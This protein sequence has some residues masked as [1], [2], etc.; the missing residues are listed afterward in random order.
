MDATNLISM[1]ARTANVYKSCKTD[2]Q[3]ESAIRYDE[4]MQRRIPDH[5]IEHY[6][7]LVDIYVGD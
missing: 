4:L 2:A 3:W 5:L 1:A 6:I 7:F